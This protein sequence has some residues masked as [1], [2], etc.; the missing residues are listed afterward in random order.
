MEAD[1]KRIAVSM[2]K[3]LFSETKD[4]K[5]PA[6]RRTRAAVAGGVGSGS[7][8]SPMQATVVKAAVRAGDRVVAGELL[9]VLEAMKMEQPLSSP[10]DG[11]VA[12]IDAPVGGTVPSGH[13]LVT[14][15]PDAA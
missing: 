4:A 3:R 9:V 10:I 7:I 11:T 6:P 2:P 12:A 15:T 1:G 14:I 5:G 8:V 13:T